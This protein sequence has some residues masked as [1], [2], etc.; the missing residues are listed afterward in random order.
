MFAA[1][2]YIVGHFGG[3][4]KLHHKY[5]VYVMLNIKW[6]SLE[7]PV[8][9]TS[10]CFAGRLLLCWRSGTA[11]PMVCTRDTALHRNY[12]RNKRGMMILLL[13][14]IYFLNLISADI[15]FSKVLCKVTMMM[16][17][18]DHHRRRRRHH[19]HFED[20]NRI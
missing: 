1:F 19:H 3:L 12:N 2:V 17:M 7:D 16:M 20:V 9:L 4:F 10:N 5:V 15:Y 18:M 8:Y 14:T 11:N 6:T 13:F